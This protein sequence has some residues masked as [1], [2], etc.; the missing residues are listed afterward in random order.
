MRAV[1]LVIVMAA[2]MTVPA[3]GQPRQVL[4]LELSLPEAGLPALGKRKA[5]PVDLSNTNLGKYADMGDPDSAFRKAVRKAQVAVWASAPYP[6]PAPLQ[7]EV[8]AARKKMKID[9][10]TLR[11]RYPIPKKP[12]AENAL[13]RQVLEVNKR[14]ARVVAYLDET[15]EELDE[16][17]KHREKECLR[18]Q[19]HHDLMRGYLRARL[20]CLEE[21]SLALGMLRKELPPHEPADKAWLLVGDRQLN[22]YTN[23]KRFKTAS[24]LF[25][26][27][28][29]EHKGTAW[30]DLAQRAKSAELSG[31]WQAV[32]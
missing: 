24:A 7:T 20:I 27:V 17:A 26:Q 11:L 1:G 29:K 22:D 32:P 5:I 25:D 23:K 8:L 30:A 12:G 19:A 15:L 31:R 13:K 18:W 6:A 3:W 10:G 21:M 16:T 14:L 4:V 9:P 2:V 28:I